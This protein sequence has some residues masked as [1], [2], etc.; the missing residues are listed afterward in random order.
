MRTEKG[1]KLLDELLTTS[2]LIEF[3]KTLLGDIEN[4][5]KEN[6][7]PAPKTWLKSNEVKALLEVSSGT[8]QN[9]RN[10]GSLPFTKIGGVIYYNHDDIQKMLL[11]NK[12]SY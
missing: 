5:F 8:L 10:N 7:K 2:D 3:R 4:L 9:M 11:E 12:Q 1:K 6:V